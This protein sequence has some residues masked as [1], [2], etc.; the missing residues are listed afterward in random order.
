MQLPAGRV[1]A[2]HAIMARVLLSAPASALLT[3]AASQALLDEVGA[4]YASSSGIALVVAPAVT[5][6]KVS[7]L[8]LLQ[9]LI[10]LTL[11]LPSA[12][13]VSSGATLKEL[14]AD[15]TIEDRGV[16]ASFLK[17]FTE[18]HG[19]YGR[20]DCRFEV[21]HRVS[22]GWCE[23]CSAWVPSEASE[24]ATQQPCAHGRW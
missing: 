10:A 12:Q 2:N 21:H 23:A 3:V 15:P 11:K 7:A 20:R 16:S 18:K 13:S 1:D 14:F 17:M 19:L 6:E 24:G 8:T 9:T 4:G 5:E 22:F